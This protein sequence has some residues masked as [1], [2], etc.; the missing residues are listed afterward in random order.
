MNKKFLSAIL[1]G[2]LAIASTG[3]FVSCA[4][5]DSDIA[6][7][8]DQNS[9]LK[10]QLASL[11]T[12]LQAELKNAASDAARAAV[13]AKLSTL[14]AATPENMA[15]TLAALQGDFKTTEAK[16][17]AL[18]TQ[19]NALKDL[20]NVDVNELISVIEKAK[21]NASSADIAGI[22]DLVN[23]LDSQVN[24]LISDIRSIVFQPEFYMDGIEA[25][26]Y[27][28]L[29]YVALDPNGDIYTE[30][31]AWSNEVSD[32]HVDYAPGGSDIY[33]YDPRNNKFKIDPSFKWGYAHT[34]DIL[35]SIKPAKWNASSLQ[36]CTYPN[37]GNVCPD[38][39]CLEPSNDC[40]IFYET[41]A[42]NYV[43][44]H[45]INYMY[46]AVNPANSAVTKEDLNIAVKNVMA[47]T[48]AGE[49]NVVIY[50]VKTVKDVADAEKEY[51]KGGVSASKNEK[52]VEVQYYITNPEAIITANNDESYSVLNK[53]QN[54]T[55]VKLQADA[56]GGLVES[57][58]AALYE[59]QIQPVAIALNA[60][61]SAD[62]KGY[63]AWYA[64]IDCQHDGNKLNELHKNPYEAAADSKRTT[65]INY[66][67]EGV[68]IAE[69]IELHF[70]K[71]D[72]EKVDRN[73]KDDH[74]L[75]GHNNANK[76]VQHPH[77]TMT[78]AEAAYKFGFTYEFNLVPYN[79]DGNKTNDSSYGHLKAGS[80]AGGKYPDLT[81]EEQ[82]GTPIFVPNT[83]DEE[84]A[85][86]EDN[87]FAYIPKKATDKS[88][89]QKDGYEQGASS[90][91]KEP[92][93]QVLVKKN[94]EVI[95]DGYVS[96]II[97]RQ[98][99]NVMSPIFDLGKQEMHCDS[100]HFHQTWNQVSELLYEYTAKDI[101][102]QGMS[103][104]EF[105]ETYEPVL[106]KN[107]NDVM[108]SKINA[109]DVPSADTTLIQ[110]N[111]AVA[112]DGTI[113]ATPLNWQNTY[114][115]VYQEFDKNGIT[116][117]VLALNIDKYDQQY[118][119]EKPERTIKLVDPQTKEVSD[120]KVPA[121]SD[122][123]YVMYKQRGTQNT[124]YSDKGSNDHGTFYGIIVPLLVTVE[125]HQAVPY[126]KYNKNFWYEEEC[127]VPET[128]I[129]KA[130]RFNVNHA[131]DLTN[132]YQY[133]YA[134][135]KPEMFTPEGAT[136]P[137]QVEGFVRDLNDA[138]EGKVINFDVPTIEAIS[139]YYTNGYLHAGKRTDVKDGWKKLEKPTYYFHP[140]N[141]G[142]TFKSDVTGN[143]Y[144]LSV[145]SQDIFCDIWVDGDD[146]CVYNGNPT[147]VHS[148]KYVT[149]TREA[150][151]A[152]SL[153]IK[154]AEKEHQVNTTK[155]IYTNIEL[156]A[157]EV[158]TGK[159]DV[160]AEMNRYTGEVHYKY[161]DMSKLVLN[162]RPHAD[163]EPEHSTDAEHV[164][165][166]K[167]EPFKV[168]VGIFLPNQCDNAYYIDYDM[169]PYN[170]LPVIYHRPIN[171]TAN[172]GEVTDAVNNADYVNLFK[173]FNFT[174]WRDYKFVDLQKNDYSNVWL[175][176]FYG[177]NRVT[178]DLE[179]VMTNM[180][181][182]NL[183]K[184]EKINED[185]KLAYVEHNK[186]TVLA[187]NDKTTAEPYSFQKTITLTPYNKAS[188]GVKSTYDKLVE[189]FGYIKYMNKGANLSQYDLYIPVTF[190]YDWGE[191]KFMAKIH[192]IGTEGNRDNEET[193]GDNNTTH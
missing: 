10:A 57:D 43:G 86:V 83:V 14:D 2:A 117:T 127:G 156:F 124:M 20:Q 48:R 6:A 109:T 90:V 157:T 46:F 175:W 62:H 19:V 59:T 176:A 96:L 107:W 154:N 100:L 78:L 132:T 129:N 94:G 178:V 80:V 167:D 61:A 84:R 55:I 141:T 67:S 150:F 29:R 81:T 26:E 85:K 71:R 183:N 97:T 104:L 121:H 130:I 170:V 112:E 115:K 144:K 185:I 99:G 37:N 45:I 163:M 102:G 140:A 68:N 53:Q 9:E 34:G 188:M 25:V 21:E 65:G 172:E 58:W 49:A 137:V 8:Q 73:H 4:D 122:V 169:V 145:K 153:I 63:P 22:S 52:I 113:T 31:Q 51:W 111:V 7:L 39:D 164:C 40:G 123:I 158:E 138:W 77:V 54:T 27:T 179:N 42:Y 139:K 147:Q 181:N 56:E 187:D 136:A 193:S 16:V 64:P 192:V 60:H 155:G 91:D 118:I 87:P 44:D 75:P 11:K 3:S 143:H 76:E 171:I 33:P 152:D 30:P 106:Y 13:E 5:N 103:K 74:N 88:V 70:V 135:D 162:A 50:D 72:W 184:L 35:S 17:I 146:P 114:T 133:K 166:L 191:I 126:S 41:K 18:Q 120:F 116:N 1:F 12:Q 89:A 180:N 98:V 38:D 134:S 101:I 186:T 173:L 28:Y 151:Q 149:V 128:P 119:Y 110:F 174:D 82:L 125:R 161:N 95:L 190:G 108:P 92:L 177:I 105:E 165:T 15:A 182:S 47:M 131:Y 93:V 160:I 159:T 142:Y 79:I 148:H 168:L 69:H 23:A 189:H 66:L 24:T 32:D 36:T